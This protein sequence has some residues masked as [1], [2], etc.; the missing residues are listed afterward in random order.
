M[1]FMCIQCFIYE[2]TFS[3]VHGFKLQTGK[4]HDDIAQTRRVV[5]LNVRPVIFMC[6][7]SPRT[8]V[9]FRTRNSLRRQSTN[10][11]QQQCRA[12]KDH[13]SI[14]HPFG[15]TAGCKWD[16]VVGVGTSAALFF[17]SIM[18][19]ITILDPVLG[20]EMFCRDVVTD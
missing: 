19:P 2:E 10:R 17:D 13:F 8:E 6:M 12:S 20:D 14:R 1:I 9:P 11:N 7:F 15:S 16:G 5:F 4:R 18:I 3:L